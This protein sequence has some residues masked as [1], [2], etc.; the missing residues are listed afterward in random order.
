MNTEISNSF[1][2]RITSAP[3][4]MLSL[5][6]LQFEFLTM[7]FSTASLKVDHNRHKM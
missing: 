4:I 5:L 1:V 7:K 3:I 6:Q 2:H